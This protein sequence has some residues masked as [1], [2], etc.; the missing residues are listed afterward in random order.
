MNNHD[1]TRRQF[2]A[3]ASAGS[4]AA[5]ASVS[6][7]AYADLTRTASKLAILGG[8]PIRKNKPWPAWPYVDDQILD[9][10]VK[11]TKSGIW[12]RIQ[13][14]SG[15][16]ATFEKEFAKL[17]GARFCVATGSG[18]Q[19]LHTCVEALGIGAG[20]EVITSPYTDPG[21]IASI[22]SAR[23][24]PV[25]ADL[26]PAS[27]QLDPEDVE[28]RITGNTRAIMPVH[29]M[30][31]PCHLERIMAIA[32]KHN[33]AV[34]E[35]AAQAHLA[36]YQGKKLGT[37]APLG[38]FSF[39]TSKTIACGEGGAIVGDDEELMD[40]CYTVHNH[41]TSRRGRTEVIGPKYRMNEFEAAILL[42]QLAGAQERFR[43]RNENAAYLTARLKGCPGVV[44]QKLYEG[45]ASGS[46]YIYALSYQKEQF[47]NVDRSRFLK[48]VE[49]EGV[50]LSPY[51]DQG[52]HKEP[53]VENIVKTRAYQKLFSP[54]RLQ[55]F[56][57]EMACPNCDRVCQELAMVWASG[58]LLGTRADMDDIADAILKVYENR[59]K[60]GSA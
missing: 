48:A 17:L 41:G 30:G 1:L 55:Q 47:N 22:L 56:R 34:I 8:E 13:S 53:W 40:K 46:F 39:Q 7:P 16:V 10:V 20:D 38:C 36:E 45:T 4:L 15:T 25:L 49:A 9:S 60:L 35:D 5:V 50:S 37:I 51:I 3:T 57:E 18:T 28:R 11:T 54:Q 14:A 29:M 58:P 33:L 21:T 27:F 52:L 32:N 59:D 26:D 42:P 19:A 24:L 23:A 43:R 2:I 6:V 44:P 31:Q 12:C